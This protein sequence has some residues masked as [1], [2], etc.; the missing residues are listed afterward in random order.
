MRPL[1]LPGFRAFAAAIAQGSVPNRC[2][3]RPDLHACAGRG[4]AKTPA[5]HR[6]SA[7]V[8]NQPVRLRGIDGLFR[9]RSD[10][11]NERGLAACGPRQAGRAVGWFAKSVAVQAFAA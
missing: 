2:E 11:T 5:G 10:G 1:I 8:L 4:L 6:Y 3:R 7:N 9:F